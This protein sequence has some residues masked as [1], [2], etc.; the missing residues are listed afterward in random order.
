MV[1]RLAG[2]HGQAG[3]SGARVTEA[4]PPSRTHKSACHSNG[5]CID[6]SKAGGMTGAE[7]AAVVQAAYANGLRPV[8]EVKT[9]AQKNALVAGGAPAANIVVLGNWI[10]APH[11]SI[12]GY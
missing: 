1:S 4:M 9:Q 2:M 5:R 12:Y 7:V 3:V 11:F 8:Y 6:Y 10:S